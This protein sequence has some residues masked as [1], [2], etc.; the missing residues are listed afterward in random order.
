[1]TELEK[2]MAD[3]QE[4]AKALIDKYSKL[5]HNTANARW[6][7]E[8]DNYYYCI[9]NNGALMCYRDMNDEKDKHNY[10]IGNYFKTEDEAIQYCANIE[11]KQKVRDIATCL[12]NGTE[13]DWEDD[14]QTKYYIYIDPKDE[15]YLNSTN[16]RALGQ[17]CCLSNLFLSDVLAELG[18]DRLRKLIKSGV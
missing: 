1:M 7:A 9:D 2:M 11:A 13:I 8:Y 17:V 10:A 5:F 16:R 12:N 15:L 18:E 6:R 3:F 14:N 4:E